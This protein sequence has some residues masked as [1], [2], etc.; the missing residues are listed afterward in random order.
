[1]ASVIF[2]CQETHSYRNFYLGSH[3]PY[4]HPTS[5]DEE[6]IIFPSKMTKV[7]T[8]DFSGEIKPIEEIKTRLVHAE[9]IFINLFH[10]EKLE[11]L[12][13][14]QKILNNASDSL[15]A[16]EIGFRVG[17]GMEGLAHKFS[18]TLP[19][20][21]ESLCIEKSI[22]AAD[23]KIKKHIDNIL[24]FFLADFLDNLPFTLKVLCIGFIE[25]FELINLPPSIE[26]VSL[27]IKRYSKDVIHRIEIGSSLKYI[28]ASVFQVH[29]WGEILYKN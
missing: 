28:V 23:I 6:I 24:A 4:S 21:V 7:L 17:K 14:L 26:L 19:K 3:D 5:G 27:G 2:S 12:E 25:I 16:L 22:N 20:S 11:H 10:P 29:G 18:I 15:K 13:Y 1:M 8:F 9:T